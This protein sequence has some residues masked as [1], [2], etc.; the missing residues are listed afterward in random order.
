M[1]SVS[2]Y[3]ITGIYV[4][5]VQTASHLLQVVIHTVRTDQTCSSLKMAKALYNK[6]SIVQPVGSEICVY[7][8]IKYARILC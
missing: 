8:S 3:Y 5:C 7:F 6:I 1:Y 4:I 2:L